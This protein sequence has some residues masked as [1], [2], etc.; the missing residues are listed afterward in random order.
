MGAMK[1]LITDM[2]AEHWRT[3]ALTA[4]RDAAD[5]MERLQKAERLNA[6]MLAALKSI[7]HW[8][9][10]NGPITDD[11]IW[12]KRFIEANNLTAAVIAKAEGTKP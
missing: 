11:G 1:N 8:L 6:E 4:Q 5:F 3:E 12:N 10:Q 2:D 7:Q 9:L